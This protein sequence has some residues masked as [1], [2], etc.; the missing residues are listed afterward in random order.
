MARDMKVLEVILAVIA[1]F[2]LS[3]AAR[4]QQQTTPR[5]GY[6]YPAGGRQGTTAEATIGGQRLDGAFEVHI[7]GTGIHAG[8][9]N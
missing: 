4:A 6:V 5:V 7:S 1:V 8:W 2:A 3:T 9:E